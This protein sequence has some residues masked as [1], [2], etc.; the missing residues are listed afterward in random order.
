MIF[1]KILPLK[2]LWILFYLYSFI[3]RIIVQT[4][5]LFKWSVHTI[6]TAFKFSKFDTIFSSLNFLF[7]GHFYYIWQN[8]RH[9]KKIL[10]LDS[11]ILHQP[12]FSCV[13]FKIKADKMVSNFESSHHALSLSIMHTSQLVSFHITYIGSFTFEMYSY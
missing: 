8:T 6:R 5:R 7:S 13:I 11:N 9:Y 2:Y 1:F 4:P 10:K 12:N 3:Y